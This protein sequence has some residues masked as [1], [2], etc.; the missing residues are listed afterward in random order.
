MLR[1]TKAMIATSARPP[2]T[3]ATMAGIQFTMS[4]SSSMRAISAQAGARTPCRDWHGPRCAGRR[5]G[6][7]LA[8]QRMRMKA[9]TG[10]AASVAISN[11]KAA[12]R[13]HAT[14][15]RVAMSSAQ[16]ILRARL[17]RRRRC[18]ASCRRRYWRQSVDR[19]LQVL[20]VEIAQ[21]GEPRGKGSVLLYVAQRRRFLAVACNG[22][23]DKDRT[24][25]AGAG[26]AAAFDFVAAEP[27]RAPVARRFNCVACERHAPCTHFHKRPRGSR[28]QHDQEYGDHDRGQNRRGADHGKIDTRHRRANHRDK[29]C[30]REDLPTEGDRVNRLPG[31]RLG[32]RYFFVCWSPGHGVSH[33]ALTLPGA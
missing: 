18:P 21:T 4:R 26:K 6:T 25:S 15:A 33:R 30:R 19:I 2:A 14:T 20:G 5:S 11:A 17:R 8:T 29:E 1:S 10:I 23:D 24:A 22:S 13:H 9:S 31:A 16:A 27:P 28:R 32:T 7:G 3:A 12:A